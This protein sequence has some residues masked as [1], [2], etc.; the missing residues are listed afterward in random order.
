MRFTFRAGDGIRTHDVQHGKKARSRSQST[1]TISA[2][3]LYSNAMHIARL[4]EKY[5]VFWGLGLVFRSL[6]SDYGQNDWTS[7]VQA[8]IRPFGPRG[9][10]L[11][12]GMAPGRALRPAAHGGIG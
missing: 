12:G 2:P 11:A 7:L 6:R 10:R 1:A 4:A 5:S 9:A 3:T 8:G